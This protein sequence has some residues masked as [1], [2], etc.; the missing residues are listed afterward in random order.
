MPS[1]REATRGQ[2]DEE[3]VA[4]R[5]GRPPLPAAAR[6]GPPQAALPP[7]L[8]ILVALFAR[9]ARAVDL[10]GDLRRA[11]PAVDGGCGG[12]GLRALRR[13]T[14]PGRGA[15]GV[16]VVQMG[17][18][19]FEV[20]TLNW[21]GQAVIHDLRTDLYRHLSGLDLAWFDKRP[22]GALV[23]RVSSDVENLAEP[24]H[25]GGRHPRVRHAQGRGG[26]GGAL[27]HPRAAGPGGHPD[28]PDPQSSAC[29]SA[30]GA[31]R[32]LSV[33]AEPPS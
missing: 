27:H 30:A 8:G 28:D 2:E 14:G 31:P 33:R 4:T 17:L 18:R 23:T 13:T 21:T 32:P 9:P 15:T 12:H 11:G 7:E 1:P 19:Y 5:A 24:V 20:A 25:L 26:A 16:L 6:C 3:P 29:R 22:T 10:G